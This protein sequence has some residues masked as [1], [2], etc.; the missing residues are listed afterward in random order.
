LLKKSMPVLSEGISKGL[1]V[2]CAV[3]HWVHL[4]GNVLSS[5]RGLCMAE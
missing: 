3:L 2:A 4:R 5:A 1:N